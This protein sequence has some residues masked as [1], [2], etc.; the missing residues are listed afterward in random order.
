MSDAPR[1]PRH[2]PCVISLAL[3]LSLSPRSSLSRSLQ[4]SLLHA[5]ALLSTAALFRIPIDDVVGLRFPSRI[6]D[7]PPLAIDLLAGHR[8]FTIAP[9]PGAGSGEFDFIFRLII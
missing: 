8:I 1:P 9:L 4:L 3:S 6:D 5:H 7:A 2:V